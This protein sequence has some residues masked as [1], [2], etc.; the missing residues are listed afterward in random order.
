[1]PPHERYVEAFCGSGAVMRMKRPARHNLAIDRSIAAITQCRDHIIAGETSGLV[2]DDVEFLNRDALELISSFNGPDTLIYCD[3]PYVHSTRTG[4]D[5]YEYEM[6]DEAHVRLLELLTA[7]GALVMLSG[8]RCALY[9]DA[10]HGWHSIDYEAQTRGGTKIETLWCNFA[11]PDALHDYSYLGTGFRERERI[12][13]KKQRWI[14]RLGKMDRLERQ[15]ILAAISAL[16]ER[17]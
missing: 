7:S 8:Y 1:M 11:P 9:D 16:N 2:L 10:L 5:L 3:P 6:P 13:R 4:G 15:A 14:A 12:K 17:D